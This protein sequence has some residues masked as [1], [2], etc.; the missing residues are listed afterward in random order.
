MRLSIEISP[1][2]H[3]RLKAAAALQ[4]KSIKDY[5]L[6]R[7]LPSKDE[8]QALNELESFLKPRIDAA[9]SGEHSTQSIDE[10]FVEVENKNRDIT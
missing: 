8:N 7:T 10:I 9:K 4:G 1:E 5:V 3:Q 2:E 6:E